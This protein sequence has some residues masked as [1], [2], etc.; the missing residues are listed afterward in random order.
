[1]PRTR[2]SKLAL[3]LLL[4]PPLFITCFG[5]LLLTSHLLVFFTSASFS[6]YIWSLRVARELNS[7][8]YPVRDVSVNDSDPP[9]FEIIDVQ[10]GNLVHGEQVKTYELVETVHKVIIEN[11]TNANFQPEAADAI[12][13][14]IF[15][16]SGG[17]Y[18]VGIDFDTAR[19]FQIGEISEETY[20]EHWSFPPNTPEIVPP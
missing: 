7:M 4:T 1:M 18:F 6:N 13:I 14:T 2:S 8:G 3:L 20:F 11:F 10:T 17:I 19:K 5:G 16:R 9:G 15:D 12:V